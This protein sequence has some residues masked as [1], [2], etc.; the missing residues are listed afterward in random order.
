MSS[1]TENTLAEPA[2]TPEAGPETADG[3][4]TSNKRSVG[5]TSF[6]QSPCTSNSQNA[7]RPFTDLSST[8]GAI[9]DSTT[10]THGMLIASLESMFQRFET[11]MNARF[12]SLD[13]RLDL[14]DTR[15][16]IAEE[17]GSSRDI[18][19]DHLDGQV[20]ELEQ[21][22][23]DMELRLAA[24]ESSLAVGSPL[25]PWQPA[26]IEAT[27][28][29]LLGDSNSGGKVRF[30]EDRG[31]IG[32]ALPG[33]GHF[34]PTLEDLPP[35]HSPVFE[36]VS[37]V[38]ISVGTNNLKLPSTD[39]EE[40]VKHTYAYVQ[41]L[42]KAHPAAHIFLPGVLPVNR[43]F[44]DE[45]MNGKI[46]L[47]NHYVKDMCKNLPTSTSYID[48]NVFREPNGAL[49][50]NLSK[51]PGDPLHLNEQ[52]VKLFASRFKHALRV[53]HNLPTTVRKNSTT[54]AR[55]PSEHTR[56]GSRGGSVVRGNPRGGGNRGHNRGG[57]YVW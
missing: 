11:I 3:G 21:K 30:G 14:L 33:V 7:K 32:R 39:P 2:V 23:S 56:G 1:I 29:L 53:Q 41:S 8:L 17:S 54:G 28:I 15:I 35:P 24:V 26:G 57:S 9:P 5:N 22:S 27:N 45:A 43:G 48:V 46:K 25:P 49:K 42:T 51:G 18:A 52:G 13:S 10:I 37:D 12:D 40:I 50:E 47:Y 20:C 34:H 4:I 55:I 44:P 36:R 19:I 31:T 16:S 6:D 38:I